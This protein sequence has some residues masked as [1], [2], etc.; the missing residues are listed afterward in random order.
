MTILSKIE[1]LRKKPKVVRV[2]YAFWMS[3]VFTAVITAFW[4]TSLSV[5]MQ[6][7]SGS[8][9]QAD[10]Q[11]I[12]SRSLSDFGNYFHTRLNSVFK[13][14][15]SP[16]V[17]TAPHATS[18]NTMNF[19]TMLKDNPPASST[20][21]ATGQVILIGTTTDAA[22]TSQTPAGTTAP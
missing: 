3:T 6:S 11:G 18:S 19:Q 4:V 2:R 17:L 21:A 16:V 10:Q 13:V 1:S 20:P 5:Q 12:V 14:T 22:A 9:P 15:S 8:V 7:M